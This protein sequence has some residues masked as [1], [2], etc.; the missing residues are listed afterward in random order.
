M[1]DIKKEI[2]ELRQKIIHHERLYFVE[3]SPE[4]SDSEF[5]ALT[6]KLKSLEE[7]HPEYITADS[8]TR[9]VGGIA[10]SFSTVGHRVPM[11]SLDN[12]YSIAEI[13]DWLVRVEKLAGSNFYPIAIEW[14]IDGVS[15]SV[16]FKNGK[17]ESAATR[18]DGNIGDSVS[19]NVKTIRS[20]PLKIQSDFDMD[21]RGEIFL[22]QTR[23]VELNEAQ[24]K[25]G[26]E[27]FKNCRNLAAGTLKNLDPQIV[28]HRNLSI[29]FYGI[30]QARELGFQTHKEVIDFL[31]KNGFTVNPNF[32]LCHNIE[33]IEKTL[34]E[35]EL[36]RQSLDYDTD[37]AVL[38]VND[39]Q[40]QNELGNTNKAPRWAIAFKFAQEQAITRLENVIWQVGR[41]QITPVAVLEPVD[42]GGTTVSRASL[43]NLDQIREKD[44][45]IGDRVRVE[46]AGYIIPYVVEALHH[47]RVGT[48]KEIVPPTSCPACDYSPLTLSSDNPEAQGAVTLFCPNPTCRGVLA[49]RIIYFVSQLDV[50]NIGPSLIERLIS[51]GF[52]SEVTDVF[53]LTLENLLMVERM[54]KKLGEKIIRNLET[55]KTAPL[56]KFIAALGIPNVGK[57]VAEDLANRFRSFSN[58]RNADFNELKS[59]YG[60][61]E[62]LAECIVSFFADPKNSLWLGELEKIMVTEIPE[63]TGDLLMGKVFVITGEATLPRREIED[64]VK[65]NG[66]KVT[67]SVSPKTSF[68]IIGS[69]EPETYSS[70]KKKRAQELKVPIIDE[71]R[72]KE[73]LGGS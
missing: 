34:K 29:F 13:K 19:D 66:G 56:S 53:T 42:L 64:L 5:D 67:S 1:S 4:I 15:A 45:R 43:H 59:L 39:L 26:E 7:A 30:A 6:R 18:G 33:E 65:K 14:K 11:M 49:R 68:L 44:I 63:D 51:A 8:P 36:A 71:I 62:K 35:M 69:K 10:N 70:S 31:R 50:E 24:I 57:V 20:L 16:T 25:N 60:I 2:D 61:G 54:G 37:G 9:R 72:L 73:T 22:K 48:E 3:M 46:K 23:L 32:W 28:S 55:A 21:L 47:M 38:K 27:P 52:L 40:L 41:A 17:Y 12:T 58:F